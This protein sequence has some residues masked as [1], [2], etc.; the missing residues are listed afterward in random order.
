MAKLNTRKIENIKSAILVVLSLS[1]IL[2]LYFFWW[3][4]SIDD[5]KFTEQLYEKDVPSTRE[6]TKPD[7]IILCFGGENY[8]MVPPNQYGLWDNNSK[9]KNSFMEQFD[10]FVRAENILVEE[11]TAKQYAEVMSYKSIQARF[12]YPIPFTSFCKEYG[13]KKRQNFGTIEMMTYIGYSE[14]SKESMFIYDGKNEKYYRL[15]SYTDHTG[16]GNII[17]KMQGKEYDPYYPLGTLLGV[18]NKTIIPISL[19]P[20]LNE[21]HAKQDINMSQNDKINKIAQTFFGESFDFIRKITEESGKTIYMYGYG[22]KT[23]IINPDGSLEYKEEVNDEKYVL[24]QYFQALNTALQFVATHGSWDSI[25][26]AKLEPYVKDVNLITGKNKGYRITFGAEVN[27]GRLLY[28]SGELITVGVVGGQVVEYKRNLI[29]YDKKVFR[30]NEYAEG[31]EAFS[32]V[33]MIAQNYKYIYNIL[34]KSGKEIEIQDSNKTF[35]DVA[36]Q[37]TK[38]EVGFLKTPSKVA[39]EYEIKPVWVVTAEGVNMYFDLYNAAPISSSS[40]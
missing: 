9:D 34:Q 6:V 35:E 29:D 18:E 33:N 28:K 40:E 30:E 38:V 11:I 8:Y 39:S 2:L 20:Q 13:L 4:A 36:K 1:T 12:S 26:G 14:A 15:N 19:K 16:I 3:G 17:D 10:K 24:Q 7:E 23:L 31:K 32:A 5:F 22:E 37:I 27:G 21:F 25:N